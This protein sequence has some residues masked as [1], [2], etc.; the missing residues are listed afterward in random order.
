MHLPLCLSRTGPLHLQSGPGVPTGGLIVNPHH[1]TG[2]PLHG[3]RPGIPELFPNGW[4]YCDAP[5]DNPSLSL[6][7][8]DSARV[9]ANS[10]YR[11]GGVWSRLGYSDSYDDLWW[12]LRPVLPLRSVAENKDV[13][14]VAQNGKYPAQWNTVAPDHL[15]VKFLLITEPSI[16]QMCLLLL[17]LLGVFE[18]LSSLVHRPSSD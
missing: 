11:I 1:S 6:G 14:T 10:I 5:V 2:V 13:C 9:R 3:G 7:G 17:C 15:W 8:W 18:V 12:G 16:G 4:R